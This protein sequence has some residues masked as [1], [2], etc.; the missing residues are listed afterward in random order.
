MGHFDLTILYK[1]NSLEFSFIGRRKFKEHK[2]AMAL[3]MT[4]PLSGRLKECFQFTSG[5][6][7]SLI[8]Y[9]H[10]RETVGI[11]IALTELL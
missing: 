6:G 5:Y 8:D 4:L 1:W 7:E 3:G 10:A 11:G 2:G 9:N